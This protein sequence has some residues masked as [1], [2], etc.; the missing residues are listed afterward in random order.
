MS[1]EENNSNGSS[2]YAENRK[3]QE[4][5]IKILY[6]G[7]C[8]PG[9]GI[10]EL[11]LAARFLPDNAQVIIRALGSQDIINKV[12]EIKKKYRLGNKLVID[13]PV[14]PEKL[15]DSARKAD[16]GVIAN[17][18]NNINN[19]LVA[20]NKL[21]EYMTA[22]LALAVS[23]LPELNKIIKENKN[24]VVFDST[25]PECIANALKKIIRNPEKLQ[26]MKQNSLRAARKYNWE[27]EEI[28]LR[29]IYKELL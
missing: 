25:R 16:I 24:G 29:K 28:K 12:K 10:E 11:G 3:K 8:I 15:I 27:N 9:R 19:Y 23:D 14:A 2:T 22:G 17:Q 4:Q 13:A 6:Q 5:K 26:K 18:P 1:K 21:F 7:G 20:P